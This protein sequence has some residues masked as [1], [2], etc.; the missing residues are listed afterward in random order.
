MHVSPPGVL[1]RVL[2]AQWQADHEMMTRRLTAERQ[3][4]EAAATPAQLHEAQARKKALAEAGAWVGLQSHVTPPPPP[5]C[6]ASAMPLALERALL[7]HLGGPEGT[8]ATR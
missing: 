3:A 7:L 5:T 2:L 1:S 8:T 4:R 6:A